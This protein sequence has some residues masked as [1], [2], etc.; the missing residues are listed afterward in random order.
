MFEILRNMFR[1]KG[2]TLLTVFGIAIG[3]LALVVMGA[4]AEKLNLLVAGGTKYYADKVQVTGEGG[5]F[6][7]TPITM[8]K[9]QEVEKVEGVDYVSPVTYSNLEKSLDAVSFGPPA[10]INASEA[11]STDYDD[12]KVRLSSG[13]RI[14]DDDRNKV[15]VGSDLVKKLNAKLN[16]EVSIRDEKFQVVGILEK[17]FTAPDNAVDVSLYDGQ[18]IMYSDQPEIIKANVKP[19]EIVYGFVAYPKE[20]VDPNKLA[21][22]IKG[23]VRGVSTVGPKGFQDTIAS[24]VKT[25][26]SIILGIG[27]VA[28]LVGT[29]SIVNTMTMSISERTKEI[30]VKKAIGAKPGSIMAEYLTEAGLIGFF[31]GLIGLGLGSLIVYGVNSYME[32][33]GDKIFLLTPQLLIGSLIFSVVIG[34]IAGIYPSYYAVKINIVKALREE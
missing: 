13:R 32:R 7:L 29:L 15:V 22:D 26:S 34:V 9:K 11:K 33:T 21:E 20:G 27:I 16:E 31:G 30:G 3:I 14:K 2:R 28:L 5:T 25:F 17:T 18:R 19:E 12:F 10:S 24:T 8:D 4:I 1:R 6:S 23:Q